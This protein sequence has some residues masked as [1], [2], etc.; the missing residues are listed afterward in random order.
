MSLKNVVKRRAHKE[1]SQPSNRARYGLL[2]KKKDYKLRA[3][4]YHRKEEKIKKLK[5]AAAM[6]NPDEFY[7][8]MIR[9]TTTVS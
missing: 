3:L 1:R 2:E 9:S 7:F 4:D 6:R 5:Q 8:K